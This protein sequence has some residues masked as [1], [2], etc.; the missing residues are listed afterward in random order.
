MVPYSEIDPKQLEIMYFNITNFTVSSM[1]LKITFAH[2]YMI[3]F[4]PLET[5]YLDLEILQSNVFITAN[6]L[7]GLPLNYTCQHWIPR[8]ISEEEAAFIAVLEEVLEDTMSIALGSQFVIN[9]FL[10]VGIKYL[11]GFMD[12]L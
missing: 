1:T 6:A 11:W 3:S 10:A 5:D 2:P 4:D 8:Q 9:V 7:A 12:T